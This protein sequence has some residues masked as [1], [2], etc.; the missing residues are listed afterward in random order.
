MSEAVAT[1]QPCDYCGSSDGATIYTDHIF[2]F[3]CEHHVQRGGQKRVGKKLGIIPVDEMEIKDIRARGITKATCQKY[4]YYVTKDDFGNSV[5][6]AN[7][8]D[9]SGVLFQK[10]RDKDKN[11]YIRGAKSYRFFG[12]HLFAK[13]RKLIVTEGEIDCLTVSQVQQNKY[14]VVSI[15]FGTKSALE[16]F[17]GNLEWLEGFDEVIAMFDMDAPGRQAVAK[18]G[19]L[20]SPHKLK[21]AQIPLKDPNECLLA[22]QADSIL[23]A[24]WNSKE[25]HPDGIKNAADIKTT[26]FNSPNAASFA[27]PWCAN[28]NKMVQGI[29]VEEM[30]LLTAGSGIGK[31]TMAREL[32]YKL[33]MQDALKIGMVMLEENPKKTLRDILSIHLQ[34]PLH[35][36]WDSMDKD[37][38]SQEYDKVFGDGN[39]VLYDHFGSL[40]SDNLIAKIRYMI[41]GEGCR[42]VVLDH[43]TIAIS[44]LDDT[45]GDERKCIDRLM[46]KLRSLSAE[47][48][49]GIV[50]ISHLRKTSGDAKAHEEGG[51]ISLDDLR[52]SGALKQLPDTIIALERNQQSDKEEVKNTLKLRVLKCRF[53]GNTGIAGRLRFNKQK[54]IIEELEELEAAE[55]TV[56]GGKAEDYGF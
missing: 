31:S 11:F 41:V 29:R 9:E 44:G 7:Y 2:C 28:L 46:T 43:I 38:L 48:G 12:Q 16:T 27:Y 55:Q 4:G 34:K 39:F 56:E 33:K 1:H 45:G 51:M 42:F 30:T 53:T 6:V 18:I 37:L 3:V 10:T 26:L 19:G 25:Y 49:A 22:G 40:E 15:P 36:C 14:P 8:N 23:N 32:A 50:I 54:N 17:K 20:L 52:G 5:Q 47:T 13:G 35:L 21:I 24:I